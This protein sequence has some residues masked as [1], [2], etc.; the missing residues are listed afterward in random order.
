[1]SPVKL[2]AVVGVCLA[3]PTLLVLGV[4]GIHRAGY[5]QGYADANAACHKTNLAALQVVLDNAQELAQ[6]AHA[7]SQALAKSIGE[8][9]Q[10][11]AKSTQ[12]LRNALALTASER[13][14]CRFDADSLLHLAAAR[15][16]AATAVAGGIGG[17]MPAAGGDGR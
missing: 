12:E 2:I 1:M 4:K 5:A 16:R 14:A 13:T 3:L 10:A 7:A 15:E 9:Q 8:R 11:D 17:A 6:N